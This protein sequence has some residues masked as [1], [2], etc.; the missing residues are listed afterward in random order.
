MIKE[1]TE[2]EYYEIDKDNPIMIKLEKSINEKL[3]HYT[4]ME[5]CNGIL[6]SSSFW[7]TNSSYLEDE[8]EI[9]YISL[10]L[11]GVIMYLQQNKEIY[12]VEVDDKF[13]V[14]N[15]IIEVLKAQQ[16]A[17]LLGAPISEGELYIL[18]VTENGNNKYLMKNYC[19][20]QGA[21]IELKNDIEC[22][23][24]RNR[25][26]YPV[27]SAKVEY[28]YAKQMITIIQDIN[29]FY[30]ELLDN[31]IEKKNIEY[32]KL[33]DTI[34][35]V[36]AHKI[37]HY[38]FFFKSEKFKNEE[39][40]RMIFLIGGAYK[41]EIV[42]YRKKLGREIPYIEVKIKAEDLLDIRLL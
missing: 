35:F 5:G 16:E 33:V 27:F 1:N 41:N 14:Y 24:S 2:L 20:E 12:Y 23:S 32:S 11:K 10:V 3:F 37:L 4:T 30:E 38:S 39:E 9:K 21:I 17:Y 6:S 40:Y 19:G 29:G 34:R 36:L 7:V 31:L 42:K 22:I 18:S 15:I 13:Q 25:N 28:D 26:I 8:T